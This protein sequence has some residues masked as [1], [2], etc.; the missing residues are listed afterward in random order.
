[1]HIKHRPPAALH[2]TGFS[3][4]SRLSFLRNHQRLNNPILQS[5]QCNFSVSFLVTLV[6]SYCKSVKKN[7][8]SRLFF[9]FF[10]KTARL[11]YQPS[12]SR[13]RQSS[14]FN[15]EESFTLRRVRSSSVI[16]PMA[17]TGSTRWTFVFTLFTFWPD[18]FATQLL[19][20]SLK[21]FLECFAGFQPSLPTFPPL[22]A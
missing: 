13:N 11:I 17:V 6:C 20:D 16:P 3:W 9:R 18:A 15:I 22:R 5:C 1:M 8:P 19:G 2:I 10:H 7:S 14:L 21:T 4:F 12:T